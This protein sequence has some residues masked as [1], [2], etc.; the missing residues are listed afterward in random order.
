MKKYTINEAVSIVDVGSKKSP[1]LTSYEIEGPEIMQV[2]DGYHTMDELYEHRIVLYV[3]LCRLL[4]KDLDHNGIWCSTKHSDGS[5]FGDWFVLGIGKEGDKDR[6]ITYHLPAR[7]WEEVCKFAK[8]LERAPKWD[9]HSSAD[10]LERL[11]HI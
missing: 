9:G 3:T 4:A 2:S 5:T 7:Y 11:K 10:V 1:R 8:V 6:Q